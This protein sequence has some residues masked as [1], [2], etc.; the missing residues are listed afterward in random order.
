MKKQLKFE[1]AV[2][3]LF[4]WNFINISLG[5]G[6]H[7]PRVQEHGRGNIDPQE[8]RGHCGLR[9]EEVRSS[10][11]LL[12]RHR[13]QAMSFRQR[14]AADILSSGGQDALVAAKIN[15]SY[16]YCWV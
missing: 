10:L 13:V 1:L 4:V 12:R 14:P 3:K 2:K 5:G 16:L 15:I 9:G 7:P 11:F 6:C 8:G